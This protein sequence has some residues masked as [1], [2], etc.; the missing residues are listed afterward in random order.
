MADPRSIPLIFASWEEAGVEQ[1][2]MTNIEI[3]GREMTDLNSIL[4]LQNLVSYGKIVSLKL[5]P[6]AELQE[7]ESYGGSK[8]KAAT[9]LLLT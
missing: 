8:N 9:W 5:I 7:W 3:H 2:R 1:S 6:Q 4:I